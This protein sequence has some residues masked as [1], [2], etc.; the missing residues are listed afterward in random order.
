MGLRGEISEIEIGH[1]HKSAYV[2]RNRAA[3]LRATQEVLASIGASAS[4]EQ[5]AAHA[6][7]SISTI[8]KHYVNKDALF[9]AAILA[10][11]NDWQ[12]WVFAQMEEFKD[13]L[14]GLVFPMRM[15]LRVRQTHPMY[16]DMIA[17]NIPAVTEILNDITEGLSANIQN[18]METGILVVESAEL[19]TELL[20]YS[21]LGI[22]REQTREL[23]SE[24]VDQAV[25]YLLPLI[26]ISKAKAKKLAHAPLPEFSQV[27]P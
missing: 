18:L 26:G 12:E 21:L 23:D 11:M 7:I 24:K 22:A 15:L 14:T 3:L 17:R 6:E 8:Y 25:E 27:Q 19:R 10:A 4:V 1:G 2:A 5:V 9:F 16:A 20:S 13:P